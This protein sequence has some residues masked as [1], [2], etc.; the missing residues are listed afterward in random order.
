[1]RNHP[2]CSQLVLDSNSENSLCK[3]F[4]CCTSRFKSTG[5]NLVALN[6]KYRKCDINDETKS[7]FNVENVAVVMDLLK[8]L[9]DR[10]A[11]DINAIT[12]MTPYSAQLCLYMKAVIRLSAAKKMHLHPKLLVATIDSMQGQET[13]YGILDLVITSGQLKSDLGFTTDNN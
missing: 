10:N 9:I 8:H 6:I 5:M 13:E 2:S 1:M 7:K 4:E 11:L 3:W 12:I